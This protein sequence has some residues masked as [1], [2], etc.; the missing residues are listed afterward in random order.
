MQRKSVEFVLDIDSNISISEMEMP[1]VSQVEDLDFLNHPH[2]SHT[3]LYNMDMQ[4]EQ[5]TT[6]SKSDS[7]YMQPDRI[8]TQFV[9]KLEDKFQKYCTSLGDYFRQR[10]ILWVLASLGSWFISQISLKT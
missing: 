9:D 10:S 5:S 8:C 1:A 2:F 7:T 4:W 6:I 3:H